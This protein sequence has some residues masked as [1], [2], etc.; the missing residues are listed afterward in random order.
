M[1]S[2]GW[3]KIS[4]TGTTSPSNQP[5]KDPFHLYSFSPHSL[6]FQQSAV[7]TVSRVHH[8]LFFV[9]HSYSASAKF[10]FSTERCHFILPCLTQWEYTVDVRS[11]NN[12]ICTSTYWNTSRIY[13]WI[14]AV[15]CSKTKRSR[16][17]NCSNV[18]LFCFFDGHVI[19]KLNS[20]FIFCYYT[21][22]T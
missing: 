16:L 9:H 6:Q 5:G 1:Y 17:K 22:C 20:T 19:P 18:Q 15:K 3:T 7:S 10:Y 4:C 11:Y 21:S 12:C 2:Q 13:I 14:A 8:S